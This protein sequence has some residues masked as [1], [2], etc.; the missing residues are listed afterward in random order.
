MTPAQVALTGEEVT[1]LIRAN[2]EKVFATM[3]GLT[4]EVRSGDWQGADAGQKG[5]VVALLGFAGDWR[6][7]GTIRCSGRLACS[8]SGKLL[9]TDYGCVNDEVLDAMGEIA[10]MIIGNFKDDAACKLGPLGLSTPTVIYGNNFEARNW[11]GQSWTG[12]AFDCEGELFEVKICLVPNG[13]RREAPRPADAP[14]GPRK[15]SLIIDY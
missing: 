10:N 3:L 6:G 13:A 5:G 15:A 2:T 11:N 9:M 7:S 8:L 1:A 12:V 4:A 14:A